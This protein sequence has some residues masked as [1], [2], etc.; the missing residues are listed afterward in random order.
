MFAKR[1]S[2]RDASQGAAVAPLG[3]EEDRL[4]LLR[5]PLVDLA[6]NWHDTQWFSLLLLLLREDLS[7]SSNWRRAQWQ[8]EMSVR[9]TLSLSILS[10]LLVI[11][12]LFLFKNAYFSAFFI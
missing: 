11:F 8:P 1:L 10:L 12:L 2:G 9:Q 5:P 6:S 3:A 4:V 7:C